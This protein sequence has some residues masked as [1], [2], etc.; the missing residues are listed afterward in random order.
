MKS[1]TRIKCNNCTRMFTSSR[2]LYNHQRTA[3]NCAPFQNTTFSC[4]ECDAIFDILSDFLEH[5]K[6]SCKTEN[7]NLMKGTE[8]TISCDPATGSSTGIFAGIINTPKGKNANRESHTKELNFMITKCK[9][10]ES[11]IEINLGIKMTRV[12]SEDSS[13]K[14]FIVHKHK[15]TDGISIYFESEGIEQ[16][17]LPT[18]PLPTTPQPLLTKKNLENYWNAKV[19]RSQ[20]NYQEK[21]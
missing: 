15:L 20:I 8:M 6:I 16:Q 4:N 17:P 13:N 2:T 9:I 3:R 18:Q 7:S 14:S 11:I 19:V 5:R 1:T 12:L 10:L 21:V